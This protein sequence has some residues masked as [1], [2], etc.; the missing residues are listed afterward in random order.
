MRKTF[1]FNLLTLAAIS[2]I[3]L[4]TVHARPGKGEERAR[5]KAMIHA[6]KSLDL[7]DEVRQEIKVT[8]RKTRR[9]MIELKSK[10]E[11][12]KVTTHELLEADEVDRQKVFAAIDA[13]AVAKA[14]VHKRRIEAMLD[15]KAKLSP[16]QRKAFSKAMEERSKHK[17]RPHHR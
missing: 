14:N 9:D 5:V 6:L 7:S 8:M 16:E 1:Y 3:A 4:G 13:L 17:D 2:L 10:L 12:A 15:I 11:L